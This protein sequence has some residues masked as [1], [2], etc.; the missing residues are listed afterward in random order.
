MNLIRKIKL[1]NLGVEPDEKTLDMIKFIES[2][3]LNLVEFKDPEY[4]YYV[5]YMKGDVNMFQYNKKNQY[6]YVRYEGLWSVFSKQFNL[7]YY[8][9]QQIM[10]DI[11]ED[12]Y[13]WKVI[14]TDYVN[15]F[16]Q[17]KLAGNTTEL[18]V[19]EKSK[20]ITI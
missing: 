15:Y 18:N 14:T 2:N 9:I 10:K 16:L 12:H 5:F 6:L 19:E 17:N 20:N 3:V 11:V 8:E 7:K 13:K 1:K 4:H